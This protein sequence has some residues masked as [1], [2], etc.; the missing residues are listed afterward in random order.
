MGIVAL[1]LSFFVQL[2][3]LI[4]GIV[5]LVQSRKAGSQERLRRVSAII[6]SSVLIVVGIIVGDRADRCPAVAGPRSTCGSARTSARARRLNGV[7]VTA[8]S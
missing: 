8:L 7:Q 5:A 6:I 2:V 4:L 3:A 1:I